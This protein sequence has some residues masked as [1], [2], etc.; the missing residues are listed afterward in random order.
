[1]GSRFQEER[2]ELDWQESSLTT[3]SNCMLWTR[4]PPGKVR[5]PLG[6]RGHSAGRALMTV[7]GTQQVLSKRRSLPAP[8]HR[9]EPGAPPGHCIWKGHTG[10]HAH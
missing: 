9:R 2:L 1:M 3:V 8:F 10:L 6:Q 4:R 7:G 5:T